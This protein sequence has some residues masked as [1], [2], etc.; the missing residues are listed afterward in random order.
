MVKRILFLIYN[1]G[2][3]AL[4]WSG[5]QNGHPPLLSSHLHLQPLC[6][7]FLSLLD[8]IRCLIIRRLITQA[9]VLVTDGR[10]V[11]IG[12]QVVLWGSAG[13]FSNISFQEP[14]VLAWGGPTSGKYS[15]YLGYF[16]LT[17]KFFGEV[18]VSQWKKAWNSSSWPKC[19]FF[20]WI[21][22][23]ILVYY[24]CCTRENLCKRA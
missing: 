21:L 16:A 4:F 10:I 3:K 2:T 7:F 5:S 17:K 11:L 15:I 22:V 12:H 20:L 24:C 13:A 23:W 9:L 1:R 18:E 19:N 8:G 14:N 6:D